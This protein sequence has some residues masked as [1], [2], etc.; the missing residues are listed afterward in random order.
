MKWLDVCSCPVNPDVMPPDRARIL[1]RSRF[2]LSWPWEV[3]RRLKHQS[4]QLSRAKRTSCF[5]N[6]SKLSRAV[7]ADSAVLLPR[8]CFVDR[9]VCDRLVIA[10]TVG[11]SLNAIHNSLFSVFDIPTDPR[12]LELLCRHARS[13]SKRHRED[14]LHIFCLQSV[15]ETAT[16]VLAVCDQRIAGSTRS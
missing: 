1:G 3:S 12:M 4:A 14:V 15:I 2:G 9:S 11:K 8:R 16:I 6:G 13:D 7:A 10:D 5:Q